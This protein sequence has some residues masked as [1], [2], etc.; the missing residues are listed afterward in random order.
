MEKLKYVIVGG[1]DILRAG[2]HIADIIEW[3]LQ[4][5][6]L[7]N[8]LK[9]LIVQKNLSEE[10]FR[11]RVAEFDHKKKLKIMQKQDEIKDKDME[12][13]TFR[14]ELVTHHSNDKRSLD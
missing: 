5:W 9:F 8:Y 1:E 13:C 3:N 7:C 10:D 4:A 6:T 2:K 11:N 12:G 14:P